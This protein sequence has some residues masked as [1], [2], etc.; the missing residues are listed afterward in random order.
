MLPAGLTSMGLKNVLISSEVGTGTRAKTHWCTTDNDINGV[1]LLELDDEL[2]AELE[3][4]EEHRA[5][6][7]QAVQELVSGEGEAAEAAAPLDSDSEDE[8]PIDPGAPAEEVAPLPSA[9]TSSGKV[10]HVLSI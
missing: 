2:L 5:A 7:L 6:L 4:P 10:Y 8:G 3:A 1:V 9:P